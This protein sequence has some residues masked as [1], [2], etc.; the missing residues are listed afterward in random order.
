[1][2]RAL[3]AKVLAAAIAAFLV[4]GVAFAGIATATDQPSFC[5]AACHEM[6]PFHAAW[7]TGPHKGVQCV[8]CH[9]DD[10]AVARMGHKVSALRE[11]AAHVRGQSRFPLVETSPIPS[12]RCRRCHSDVRLDSPGFS[13]DQHA[14]RGECVMCHATVGHNVTADALKTAGVY[15]ASTKQAFD[16][17]KTAIVDG[18]KAD[19]EGH[20]KVTCSR[21]H[22]M[23]ASA[24]SECHKPPHA[25]RKAPC[26]TC[27]KPGEKFVFTHPASEQC[28]TCHTP[29]KTQHTW[30]AGC[31]TCH[32]N[33]GKDWAFSHPA[34]DATC[35]T[36][37]QA[38]AKHRSGSCSSCHAAGKSWKFRHPSS[39]AECTSCH[40]AP[41]KHRSGSC[42]SCHATGSSWEF[43][44]PGSGT[45][46]TSCHNRPSGHSS[47][48]CA[49]CHKTGSS[50]KFTHPSGSACA[51]CHTAPSS[52]YGSGWSSCHSPSSKWTSAKISHP[53][54]PGGEHSYKSFACTKCHPS[55]GKGP[56]HYCSCHKSANGPKD[57]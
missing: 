40:K 57:D 6:G 43:S 14:A 23:A 31:P 25:D 9:V 35:T 54:I 4:A 20:V 51:S 29:S 15:N 21:C 48:A 42:T 55:G 24:C 19:L 5:G 33:A 7:T 34:S 22:V 30:T 50:W 13:H 11:V 36:C 45:D 16:T 44:H 28:G 27:H 1:M 47:G 18:G 32:Q 37:H 41:A 38:P 39:D 3:L 52:H 8:D 12:E 53:R 2:D 26:S 46:C 56:G 10:G 49:G 17:S